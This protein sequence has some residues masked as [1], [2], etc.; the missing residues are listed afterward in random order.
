[1]P[2]TPQ[3]LTP[4]AV[5]RTTLAGT[6]PA[7]RRVG[8]T[9]SRRIAGLLVLLGAALSACVPAQTV[10]DALPGADEAVRWP[11]QVQS[12]VDLW[13]HGFGMI[14]TDTTPV[15]LFRRGYRDSLTV[16]KNGTNA[17]T[18]LDANRA[19][20]SKT[21]GN[22]PALTN[23]QFLVFSFPTWESLSG[24]I[25]LFLKLEGDAQR[26]PNEQSGAEVAFLAAQFPTAADRT[27]LRRF[28]DGLTDERNAFY[29]AYWTRAQRDQTAVLTAVT[30][31]WEQQY[32][33]QFQRF[34]SNTQQ[35][36]GTMV[37]SLPLGPEG[38][39]ASNR[40]GGAVIAVPFPG[41]VEDA[42][43]ALLVFAHEVVGSIAGAAVND[44]TTPA[45]KRSGD[46]ARFVALAQVR[47]GAM[48][49]E[50]IAPELVNAYAQY[51]LA[52]GGHRVAARGTDKE[53]LSALAAAYPLPQAVVDGMKRQIEIALGGI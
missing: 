23:A 13:L 45:E 26:A 11:V 25:D 30:Q 8:A 35:R 3:I 34:L 14:T 21:L 27:W 32:R 53:R 43:E 47:A 38:R 52:Q 1:M 2:S 19:E 5:G 37:L 12:H 24:A 41:R 6:R 46:A 17:Y 16:I 50:N 39:A 10:P 51:Y 40:E 7:A 15:P 33:N 49:L 22:T 29:Q 20:L 9:P 4:A 28:Y 18:T 36:N 31:L 48:L 42:R 44:N